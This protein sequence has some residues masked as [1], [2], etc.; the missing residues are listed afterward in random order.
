MNDDKNK[1][2]I[3]KIKHILI[4]LFRICAF[5]FLQ[6]FFGCKM[7]VALIKFSMLAAS[8]EPFLSITRFLIVLPGIIF[9]L[10]GLALSMLV[11]ICIFACTPN[12]IFAKITGLF[13]PLDKFTKLQKFSIIIIVNI[14]YLAFHHYAHR[15]G[16]LE[17]RNFLY[18]YYSTMFFS[19]SYFVYLFFN[20]LSKKFKFAKQIGY[21]TSIEFVKDVLEKIKK[22][23]ANKS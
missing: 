14:V 9:D 15:G 10:A 3:D 2:I 4:Y 20:F 8:H 5:L 21:L 6:S 1:I 7:C 17:D 23:Y 18:F 19:L 12:Y 11:L 22:L 13:K 16:T